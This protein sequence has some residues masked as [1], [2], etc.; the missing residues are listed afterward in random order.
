[1]FMQLNCIK[2][3]NFKVMQFFLKSCKFVTP[4][5]SSNLIED[6]L[7]KSAAIAA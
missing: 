6:F 3:A 4:S 7:E 1:M 5:D 2:S